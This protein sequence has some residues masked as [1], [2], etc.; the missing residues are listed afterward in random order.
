MI[1]ELLVEDTWPREASVIV[2]EADTGSDQCVCVMKLGATGLML[3]TPRGPSTSLVDKYTNSTIRNFLNVM[4][5][6]QKVTGRYCWLN[7]HV[8]DQKWALMFRRIICQIIDTDI[9]DFN[10]RI[11]VLLFYPHFNSLV[12]VSVLL[13]SII[14][15][16]QVFWWS[17]FKHNNVNLRNL[18]KNRK[19]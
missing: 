11:P 12:S 18:E 14:S 2:T 5:Y 6:K 15:L 4:K 1:F 9:Q 13:E 8:F 3:I 16:T 7:E 19:I 17:Q 10:S